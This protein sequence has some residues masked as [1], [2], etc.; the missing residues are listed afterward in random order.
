MIYSQFYVCL[1][2][3]SQEDLVLCYGKGCVLPELQKNRKC[4]GIVHI[5]EESHGSLQAFKLSLAC[6]QPLL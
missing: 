5:P 3:Y 6:C 2:K 4:L 1:L